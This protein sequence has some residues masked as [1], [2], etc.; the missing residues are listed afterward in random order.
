MVG[1]RSGCND[2]L[3][4]EDH[5]PNLLG[6]GAEEVWLTNPFDPALGVGFKAGKTARLVAAGG[7]NEIPGALG[8]MDNDDD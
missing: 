2:H 8:L 5:P 7:T 3:P 1:R 6:A 4:I